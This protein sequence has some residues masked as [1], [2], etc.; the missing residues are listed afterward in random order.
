MTNSLAPFLPTVVGTGLKALRNRILM[1]RLFRQDIAMNPASVGETVSVVTGIT[2]ISAA[3]ASPSSTPLDPGA[4]AVS[5]TDVT[6]SNW[7]YTAFHVT[8]KEL[9]TISDGLI[10]VALDEAMATLAESIDDSLWGMYKYASWS[11]GT[12]ATAP[13]GG[14]QDE[15]DLLEARKK[16]LRWSDKHDDGNLYCVMDRNAE[17]NLLATNTMLNASNSGSNEAL[18]T[19]SLGQ[20]FGVQL[21]ASNNVPL[22]TTT[23]DN[24]WLTNGGEAA[25]ATSVTVDT[26]STGPVL[27][28]IFSV[29]DDA[30]ANTYSVS[31]AT[32][33]EWTLCTPL[34]GLIADEKAITFKASHRANLL[35]HRDF[36]V[37]VQRPLTS[38]AGQEGYASNEFVMQD[39][40][41][42]LILRG[43]LQQQAFRTIVVFDCLWGVACVN[44]RLACRIM[45]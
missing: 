1:P 20:R 33:T 24:N 37:F 45:G 15:L 42:G 26:G 5:S 40:E 18:M 3:N 16:V 12:A 38:L 22:H 8:D 29:A 39:P 34:E 30:T 17:Y 41:T 2:G 19:G 7:K 10:P 13:F 23:S 43:S 4:I 25:A 36:A 27:G 35:F 44:P 31:S 28:D 14:S 9:G 21:F 11:C 6:L 32:A